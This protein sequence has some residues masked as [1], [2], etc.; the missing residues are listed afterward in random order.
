MSD[1]G[2]VDVIIW[3]EDVLESLRLVRSYGG[4]IAYNYYGPPRLTQDVDILVLMHDVKMP[5]LVDAFRRAECLHGDRDPRPADLDA[6]LADFRSATHFAVFQRGGV[7]IEMF[8]P[9]HPFH[10]RVLERSPARDLEGRLIRIH[11]PEDLIIFKKIFDRPKDIGDIKA[12]LMAQQGKLDLAR[13]KADAATLLS[14]ESCGELESLIAEYGR[15]SG[16]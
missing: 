8:V 16:P 14:A 9:W 5:A 13:L 12:M 6:V 11:A 7:R 10:H 2:L 1:L 4:A 3:L 15:A